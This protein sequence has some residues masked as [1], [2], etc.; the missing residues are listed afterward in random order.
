ML[1]F[2]V[3]K[4]GTSNEK[5]NAL[6]FTRKTLSDEFMFDSGEDGAASVITSGHESRININNNVAGVIQSLNESMSSFATTLERLFKEPEKEYKMLI[7]EH[8]IFQRDNRL[9]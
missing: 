9:P 7:R 2:S 4:C 6:Y 8:G 1:I 5:R 3:Y